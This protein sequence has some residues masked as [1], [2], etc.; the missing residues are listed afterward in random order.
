MSSKFEG[1]LGDIFASTNIGD[2]SKEKCRK[3]LRRLEVNISSTRF[4]QA[5]YRNLFQTWVFNTLRH[6]ARRGLIHLKPH[7]LPNKMKDILFFAQL[8]GAPELPLKIKYNLNKW[9]K[10]VAIKISDEFRGVGSQ[11]AR[12]LLFKE[13]L[14]LCKELRYNGPKTS[15]YQSRKAGLMLLL[16][17][18]TG[19]RLGDLERVQ[20]FQKQICNFQ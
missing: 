13:G 11:Q 9:A 2:S 1:K 4:S 5:W 19:S 6:H 12:P 15:E 16:C 20:N 10:N 18:Y 14:K 7:T 3:L 8:E 17:L